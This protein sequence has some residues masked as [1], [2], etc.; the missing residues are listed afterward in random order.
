MSRSDVMVGST[1]EVHIECL[2]EHYTT[3]SWAKGGG[4]NMHRVP[5][6]LGRERE[7]RKDFHRKYAATYASICSTR[8]LA[9][10]SVGFLS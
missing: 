5:A 3:L 8:K 2:G 1:G 9:L 6:L 7:H 4:A 10:H